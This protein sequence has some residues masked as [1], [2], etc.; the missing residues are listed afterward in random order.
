M[1]YESNHKFY[2]KTCL[3]VLNSFPR[4]NYNL[5][6]GHLNTSIGCKTLGMDLNNFLDK[7]K[8][9]VVYIHAHNNNGINDEHKSLDK[10][11]LDWREV[12]NRL[13]IFKARKIII[14]IKTKEDILNTK[15]LL[16]D[17]LRKRE[18]NETRGKTSTKRV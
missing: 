14:E 9:R 2:S 7:I 1:I 11:T 12:L 18:K 5:D 4:L 15:R 3:D 13:N 10:G 8:S 17:Y 16:E 6:L